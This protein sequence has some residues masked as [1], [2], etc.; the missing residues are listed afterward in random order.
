[1]PILNGFKAV[2]ETLSQRSKNGR[3]VGSSAAL[4]GPRLDLTH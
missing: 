4:G 1:M 3:G 2:L